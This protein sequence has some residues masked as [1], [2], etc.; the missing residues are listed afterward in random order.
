VKSILS[1]VDSDFNLNQKNKLGLT[2]LDWAIEGRKKDVVNFLLE[3]PRWNINTGGSN[4]RCSLNFAIQAANYSAAEDILNSSK[5]VNFNILDDSNNNVFH[6]LMDKFFNQRSQRVLD[7]MKLLFNKISICHKYLLSQYNSDMH[8]PLHWVLRTRN[9][10]GIVEYLKSVKEYNYDFD[11][12]ISQPAG[13]DRFPLIHYF[14]ITLKTHEADYVFHRFSEINLF[15]RDDRGVTANLFE[16]YS[17]NNFDNSKRWALIKHQQKMLTQKFQKSFRSYAKIKNVE[18]YDN[19]EYHAYTTVL[20]KLRQHNQKSLIK[21]KR[22]MYKFRLET[23]NFWRLDKKEIANDTI[24]EDTL[25]YD[26]KPQL[27]EEEIESEDTTAVGTSWGIHHLVNTMKINPRRKTEIDSSHASKMKSDHFST[28]DDPFWDIDNISRFD[29]FNRKEK[30]KWKYV[31]YGLSTTPRRAL[32]PSGLRLPSPFI[33]PPFLDLMKFKKS[34]VVNLMSPSVNM[35]ALV[36]QLLFQINDFSEITHLPTWTLIIDILTLIPINKD[37]LL[38]IKELSLNIRKKWSDKENSRTHPQDLGK[39]LEIKKQ[40]KMFVFLLRARASNWKQDKIEKLKK[41]CKTKVYDRFK[42]GILTD[43][44]WRKSRRQNSAFGIQSTCTLNLPLEKYRINT[45]Q[46][47][48]VQALTF[49][50]TWINFNT[51]LIKRSQLMIRKSDPHTLSARFVKP[52][53]KQIW[54]SFLFNNGVKN[55][56]PSY[57]KKSRPKTIKEVNRVEKNKRQKPRIVINL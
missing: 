6:I 9:K 56:F 4:K 38:R 35:N 45:S 32:T 13:Y 16:C 30:K 57:C 25:V 23:A 8:T 50:L 24:Y 3:N 26:T 48:W 27:Q 40:L 52:E 12:I 10:L 47:R 55:K 11:K 37:L 33:S 1:R 41:I 7:L 18:Q 17:S 36:S 31:P 43:R 5:A 39:F 54:D 44:S 49:R 15:A 20:R 46:E 34:L 28:E 19:S 42:S 51:S 22:E 2:A 29:Y 14:G 53:Q 21:K